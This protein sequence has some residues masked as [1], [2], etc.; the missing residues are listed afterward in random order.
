MDSLISFAYTGNITLTVDNVESLII[1]VDYLQLTDIKQE[2]EKFLVSELR[3]KNVGKMY[4]LAD[5]LHCSSLKETSYRFMRLAIFHLV[6]TKDFF[7]FDFSLLTDVLITNDLRHTIFSP[8]E[9]FG[10]IV[11]WLANNFNDRKLHL[12]E[13]MRCANFS[14]ITFEDLHNHIYNHE[15]VAKLSER[16]HR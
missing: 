11:K 2:C 4:Q 12:P 7:D 16:E 15:V 5:A 9:L 10:I 3:L 6:E 1:D 8:S 14:A 13:L